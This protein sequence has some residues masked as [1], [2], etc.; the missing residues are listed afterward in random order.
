MKKLDFVKITNVKPYESFDLKCGMYGIIVKLNEFDADVMFFNPQNVGDYAV[1]NINLKDL[2][3]KNEKFPVEYEKEF[4][5]KLDNILLKAKKQ[6]KPIKIKDY[7]IV[8]LLVEDK[9]YADFGIHK[10]DRGCVMDS[11]AVQN[12][13]EVDFSGIDEEGNYY[14]DCIS[15]DIDDL[16]V[17]E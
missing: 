2:E 6:F 4:L 8:E 5:E 17:I 3:Q 13:I 11:L 16:K 7:D 14:G 1:R 15:V 9:K 12:Y 10:G